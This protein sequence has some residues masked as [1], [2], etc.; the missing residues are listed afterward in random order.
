MKPDAKFKR[1]DWKHRGYVDVPTVKASTA[2]RFLEENKQRATQQSARL[3]PAMTRAE[4]FDML[5]KDIERLDDD[6]PIHY[7]IYKN[8]LREFGG[9]R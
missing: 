6:A 5:N 1:W 4:A 2:R 7:R 3:N 9:K 8:I